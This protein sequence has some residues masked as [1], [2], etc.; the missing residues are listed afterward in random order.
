MLDTIPHDPPIANKIYRKGVQGAG[1][2]GLTVGQQDSVALTHSTS[3]ALSTPKS[4]DG[5]S[6]PSSMQGVVEHALPG[7]VQQ[8]QARANT[9]RSAN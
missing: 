4:G 7:P 5:Q 1:E 6:I 3:M 8:Y 9:D 2:P